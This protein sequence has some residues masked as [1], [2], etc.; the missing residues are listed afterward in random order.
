M[1][2]LHI[3]KYYPPVAGGME[4][5]VS[6]LVDTQRR[7]GDEVAVLVH[8]SSS[9]GGGADPAWLWRCPVWFRLIFAPISPG[10]PLWLRRAIRAQMPDILHLHMPNLSAFW[11][12][13]LPSARR[14]PWVVHWHADVVPSKHKLGLRLAYPLYRI[15]ERYILDRADVVVATSKPYL[16]SSKP[17]APWHDKCRVVPLGM[18]PSRLPENPEAT[19]SEAW[20]SQG[21]RVL[22]I[23]RL[24]YYK[25]FETLVQAVIRTPGVELV[26]IG[27]GEEHIRIQ[28]LLDQAGNPARIRLLGKQDDFVCARYLSTCDVFCLPSR[29]RTEA[30]GIVLL[31]AMRYGKPLLVSALQGSG[32]TWVAQN[33]V[34]A[35]HAQ[36]ENA[37]DFAA[38][39]GELA[40]DP[41]LR[42]RL[43][44]AGRRRFA[45]AF[46]IDAV[47]SRLHDIY[48]SLVP[49][50]R[51]DASRGAL[52]VIPA[53]NEAGS[54]VAVIERTRQAGYRDVLVV[55]D[56]ST[57]ETATLARAAGATVITSPLGQG[58]W[59]AMQTGIRY[60]LREGYSGVITLDAD[61]QHDPRDIDALLEGGCKHDVVIGACPQRGSPLR[62]LAW[63]YFRAITGFNL[64]DLTS[65]YR[66]YNRRAC[67]LLAGEEATLL[68]YQDIGVLLLLSKAGCSIAEI[69]VSMTA[70]E[71]GASRIFSSW[72]TVARYMAETTL[73]CLARW[74][75]SSRS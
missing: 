52:V 49:S 67:K 6:D 15:L 23:G 39:L 41:E 9:M 7:C 25:G 60:A 20:L 18:L 61:G 55:D 71:I 75:T 13:A 5:F 57:D 34:N 10:F 33:H 54:I 48:A 50:P 53:L 11:A 37:L 19:G 35:L 68:D 43:G 12:L 69:P 63:R 16:D 56:R 74:D 51:T 1:R 46:D 65:G 36:P 8:S 58:A 14:L 72:W 32:M 42:L 3:G 21:L 64:E 73:L 38:K 17:L 66:Y 45:D 31:E 62:K 2:I 44:E 26:L 24:S 4:R 47:A 40:R 22:S 70:R 28:N 29:E 59:G 27:E 30:F